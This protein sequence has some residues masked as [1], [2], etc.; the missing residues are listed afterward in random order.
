KESLLIDFSEGKFQILSSK[1]K[2]AGSGCNFQHSCFNMIFVGI[3][4]KFND[5]IQAIHRCFRF[6]QLK[7]VNVYVILTQ[8]EHAVLKSL[9]TKWK[10]HIEL[11]TEMINI[12]RE[13]GLSSDKIKADMKRQLFS[14]PRSATVGGATV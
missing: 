13:Y 2:I 5:F 12:V 7:E 14:S 1:P 9:K 8:N 4:F 11:Q 3:D 10:N 6:R